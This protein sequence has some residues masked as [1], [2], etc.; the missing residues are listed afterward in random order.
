MK[1]QLVFYFLLLQTSFLAAQTNYFRHI[2]EEDGLSNNTVFC[3]TEDKYGYMWLGT[4]D[5]LCRY[6]GQIFKVFVP[7]K[8]R[9]QSLQTNYIR[10]LHHDRLGNLWIGTNMGLY[11][12]D[13]QTE[14]F[15][16]IDIR[17]EHKAAMSGLIRKILLDKKEN[18]WVISQSTLFKYNL[19]SK[20]VKSYPNMDVYSLCEL[21][22]GDIWIYTSDKKMQLYNSRNESF[23]AYPVFLESNNN[24][25]ECIAPYRDSGIMIGTINNGVILFDVSSKKST[26][27]V[28]CGKNNFVRCFLEYSPDVYWIGTEKGIFIYNTAT[29]QTELMEMEFG[30][31][32][33]L[34][35]NAIYDLYRDKEGG[36]WVGTFF[37][38]INYHSAEYE[39]FTKYLPGNNPDQLKGKA[40]RDIKKDRYGNLWIGTEDG[41]LHK[42]SPHSREFTNLSIKDGLPGSNIQALLPDSDDLLVATYESGLSILNIPTG[43]IRSYYPIGIG[44]NHPS[45]SIYSILK[46]R[47]GTIYLATV[48]GYEIF[49]KETGTFEYFGNQIPWH[50]SSMLEDH[51]GTVWFTTISG[52]VYSLDTQTYMLN[53]YISDPENENSLSHNVVNFV[54]EDHR[55]N[56]W[57]ATNNG[58]CSLD[59]SRQNFHRYDVS[60]GLPGNFILCIEEDNDSNLWLST[61]HGLCRFNPV[62]ME[63]KNY[64]QDGGLVCNQFNLNS[65][66]KDEDG[67]LYF[68]SI[69]GLISFHPEKMAVNNYVPPVMISGLTINDKEQTIKDDGILKSTIIEQKKITLKHNESNISLVFS[70]LSYVAPQMNLYAYRLCG[71]DENWVYCSNRNTVSYSKLSPGKYV[72]QV[73]AANS[74]GVWNEHP[75]TLE[76]EIMPPFWKSIWAYVLYW[77]S[78]IFL[79]ASLFRFY[80]NKMKIKEERRKE[81]YEREKEKEIYQIKIDFFTNVAHEIKTP[82]SLIKSPLD[83][84]SKTQDINPLIKE[85]LTIIEKNTMRLITLVNQLLDFRKAEKDSFELHTSIASL[86]DMLSGV[87][88]RFKPTFIERGLPVEQIIPDKPVYA[89]L[90]KEATTKIISNLLSNALKYAGTKII[91]VLER[92]ILSNRCRLSVKNDGPT[93]PP[94]LSDKIFEPF[95][96]LE[97]SLAI[98][99][100]GI[101][102]SLAKSLAELQKGELTYS[103]DRENLNVFTF[104]LPMEQCPETVSEPAFLEDTNCCS[105]KTNPKRVSVLVVE[106]NPEMNRFL[107]Q[108]LSSEYCVFRAENGEQALQILQTES[109][110]LI[111]SD[112]MMPVMDGFEL[113]RI[114]KTTLEYSHIPVVLLTAKS[115][116]QAR[117]EGLENGADA[118]IEKP[119]DMELVVTQITTLIHSRNVI[120]NYFSQSPLIHLKEMAHSKTDEH[121]LEKTSRLITEHINDPDLSPNMLADKMNM[122]RPTFYRKI[123]AISN[124][125]PNEFIN[126]IR[127]RRAAEL[128]TGGNCRINE[129][130]ESAGFSS[131]TYFARLFHKQFGVKPSEYGKKR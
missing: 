29:K 52:G 88:I 37:G 9:P 110:Q 63:V 127:L 102:L 7:D 85:N 61:S 11:Q 66:F 17:T 49:H 14:T 94:E 43:K 59:P 105:T 82:L 73:K 50:I 122:S 118:Y 25:V 129:I 76:I 90:D 36:I 26:P 45:H 106:D 60:S 104:S 46:T 8:K 35:D 113:T 38:G 125:T 54:Y 19:R 81:I 41:G 33:K 95:Y 70:A 51:N 31:P 10:S 47:N 98:E 30:N 112:V 57:F 114:V 28:A 77:L 69:N 109:I 120:M 58:L 116:L 13:Y 1:K 123:K 32:Y 79:F 130:A 72:F 89:N 126:I 119:F 67:A 20:T 115:S 34:N 39:N 62:T 56:L 24:W 64:T 68:G 107:S 111:L 99:G 6:D 15:H 103:I 96:R 12:Y 100:I 55:Q 80:R 71:I 42:L 86:N 18:L 124:T 108:E 75:Q 21:D 2:R 27:L 91:I 131:S 101:G 44:R 97:G 48:S 3:V 22:N 74:S 16:Y 92:D 23:S 84:I 78:G 4:K 93:V 65:S 121:F 53:N 5:G 128:L 87:V 83:K 117:I 40:V